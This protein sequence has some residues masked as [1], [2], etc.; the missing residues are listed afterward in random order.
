M[1]PVSD[2]EKIAELERQ[3]SQ[4]RE[5]LTTDEL[6]KI[7]NRKGLTDILKPWIR[8]VAYQLANPNRRKTLTVRAFSLIFVD[9]DHFKKV[10]DVY[11]HQ[12]GDVALKTVARILKDNVREVDIVGRYGG[13]EMV[14]GL[15]GANIN[16]A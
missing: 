6:T 15:I 9:L 7:L 13:E 11:G 10:N 8:E 12:A 5:Q 4:L 16:D 1:V 14:I 3:I 2:E